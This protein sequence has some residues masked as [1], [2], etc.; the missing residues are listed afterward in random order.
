MGEEDGEIL[1]NSWHLKS[2][3]VTVTLGWCPWFVALLLTRLSFSWP[4]CLD[5]EVSGPS[6]VWLDGS[7]SQARHLAVS[8]H[9]SSGAEFCCGVLWIRF[10]TDYRATPA[11]GCSGRVTVN[12]WLESNWKQDLWNEEGCP[13]CSKGVPLFCFGAGL[14]DTAVSSCW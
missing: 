8:Y 13:V 3:S 7:R 5:A 14:N 12:S 2:W 9:G 1:A 4:S 10:E 6:A 11:S